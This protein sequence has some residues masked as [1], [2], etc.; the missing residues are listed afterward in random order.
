MILNKQVN[1]PLKQ[2]SAITQWQL[3]TIYKI[4]DDYQALTQVRIVRIVRP[5]RS[6]QT[7]QVIQ[8]D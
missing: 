3:S 5:S 1:K 2:L 7:N 6:I 8:R 4:L